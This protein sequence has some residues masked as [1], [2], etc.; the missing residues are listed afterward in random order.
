E[1]EPFAKTA[2]GAHGALID[3]AGTAPRPS[4]KP[5]YKTKAMDPGYKGEHIPGNKIWGSAVEYLDPTAR[6]AFRLVIKDGKVYDASGKLF[7]TA[8]G[9][10]VHSGDGRAIFV[11]DAEGSFYASKFQEVGKFHHSS[12]LAGEPAAAAGELGVVKGEI[13][14]LSD[15]SGH[16]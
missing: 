8:T 1:T 11:M 6:Q 15:R 10:T 9:A 12:L 4:P 5:A 3:K 7:D 16:Y 14:V 2:G 13:K